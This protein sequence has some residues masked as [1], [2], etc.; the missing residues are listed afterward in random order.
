MRRRRFLEDSALAC[1]L[2]LLN[3]RLEIGAMLRLEIGAVLRL[4]IDMTQLTQE[5]GV[6]THCCVVDVRRITPPH[7][8]TAHATQWRLSVLPR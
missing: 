2:G 7:R 3:I 6:D 5:A 8:R 4:E 1:W